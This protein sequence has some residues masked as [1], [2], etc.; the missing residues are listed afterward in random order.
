MK[1]KDLAPVKS[2]LTF[3]E[4]IEKERLRESIIGN[5][6]KLTDVLKY[7]I[8]SDD[9][10]LSKSTI[11][12]FEDRGR[13]LKIIANNMAFKNLNNVIKQTDFDNTV[14]TGL[15]KHIIGEPQNIPKFSDAFTVD[16]K[17]PKYFDVISKSLQLTAASKSALNLSA[18]ASI[19]NSM[20]L[21]STIAKDIISS[22]NAAN[23][24]GLK[25][26]KLIAQSMNTSALNSVAESISA[27]RLKNHTRTYESFFNSVSPISK[28][29]FTELARL[30][31]QVKELKPADFINSN[32]FIIAKKIESELVEYDP[33]VNV[34]PIT[35]LE[36]SIQ[37]EDPDAFLK[38]REVVEVIEVI[39]QSQVRNA[40]VPIIE[41]NPIKKNQLDIL[42]ITGLPLELN[43]FRNIFQVDSRWQS[44][45]FHAQYYF[46][47][48]NS[49]YRTYTIALACGQD[50]G[51][52]HASQITNAA[53]EDLR[54]KIVI[55]AGIGYTL[56]PNKLQLCDLHIT[57]TILHWGLTSKEYQEGRKVRSTHAQTKSIHLFQEIRDYEAGLKNGKISFQ[58]WRADSTCKQPKISVAKVK[59][60]LKDIH[61]SINCGVPEKFFNEQPNIIV[62]STM[63]SDDAVIASLEEI[64][65]R[66]L[67]A[68]GIEAQVSGEMEAAG[69]S[70]SIA[71]RKTPIEFIA[72][73]GMSDFGFGKE[74]LEEKSKEFR[75]IAATRVA[76]FLVSLIKSDLTL[77]KNGAG[78]ITELGSELPVST[79]N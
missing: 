19:A 26:S 55:S 14:K 16:I 56:N 20:N 74:A 41:N 23:L 24:M 10:S 35:V 5:S 8:Q 64:N 53:L 6:S 22:S 15:Q 62:G 34:L 40:D 43:I 75:N 3:I 69:I 76:T 37:S 51:N 28:I 18:F 13:K 33:S 48:I 21:S 49:D 50:M 27:L 11:K 44:D 66:S 61:G 12:E 59:K 2:N 39:E 68:A 58:Q 32:A 25:A 67:F 46:G 54:P 1:K 71:I 78:R 60:V 72:I 57:N 47:K 31:S 38:A 36:K 65:K 30:E 9:L 45:K 79:K 70:M 17:N 52:F 63:V 7:A 73:R 77:P 4:I 29:Y 42:I